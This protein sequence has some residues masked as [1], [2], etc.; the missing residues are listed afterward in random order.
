MTVCMEKY[1]TWLTLA[2][3]S[4]SSESRSVSSSSTSFLS[5]P[6]FPSISAT[7]FSENLEREREILRPL[8]SKSI[9]R[10]KIWRQA[11]G[12]LIC[13]L[14]K[15]KLCGCH[16]VGTQQY[17]TKTL[18]LPFTVS[19]IMCQS[20]AYLFVVIWHSWHTCTPEDELKR[21]GRVFQTDRHIVPESISWSLSV[22]RTPVPS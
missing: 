15:Q 16:Y 17:R 8:T 13:L 18:A 9:V 14:T 6:S 7:S 10:E 22:V 3:R 5:L 19:L 11:C 2:S 21:I 1:N 20:R 12:E 4:G